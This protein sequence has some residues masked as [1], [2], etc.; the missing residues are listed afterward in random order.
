MDKGEKKPRVLIVE[1]ERRIIKLLKISFQLAG[2][3]VSSA[4]DGREAL[5]LIESEPPDIMVL[6]IIL[7]EMGGLELLET[8][9]PTRRF[10]VIAISSNLNLKTGAMK[11][12]AENFIVKPFNPGTVVSTAIALLKR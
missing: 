10:P 1:D 11:L 9:A 2:F 12:G 7:P 6:D 3:T 5:S 8:L 4:Q